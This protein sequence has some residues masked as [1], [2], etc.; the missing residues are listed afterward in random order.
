MSNKD[1]EKEKGGARQHG[2]GDQPTDLTPLLEARAEADQHKSAAEEYLNLLRRVQADFVNYKRRVEA[3][4]ESSAETIR[5][6]TVR[7]FLPL[8]DDFERAMAHLPPPMADEGWAQG[9][10]LIERNLAAALE[11]L[12]VRRLGVEGEV[13]DPNLH[14]AVAYEEHPNQPEGHVSAVHR[15]GYQLGERVVRPAQV[16]VSRSAPARDAQTGDAWRTHEGRARPGNGGVQ[17]SDLSRP[18]NIERA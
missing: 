13:F 4:R 10:R 3:E 8:I 11:Q 9:F 5:A 1:R 17:R 7:A 14:E 12:G 16:S 15:T 6:D 2:Q 18:R